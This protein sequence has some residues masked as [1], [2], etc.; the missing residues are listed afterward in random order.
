MFMQ[1]LHVRVGRRLTIGYPLLDSIL[2]TIAVLAASVCV[3]L[4]FC[5]PQSCRRTGVRTTRRDSSQLVRT[6]SRI[7]SPCRP[8][9]PR[10]VRTL[11][12]IPP[13]LPPSSMPRE[14][15]PTYRQTCP[16][17]IPTGVLVDDESADN[18]PAPR[19]N[20]PT[21]PASFPAALASTAV[22]A[23]SVATSIAASA[24]A[25][26]AAAA[27]L[28]ASLATATISTATQPVSLAVVTIS[29]T[30]QPASVATTVPADA[31]SAAGITPIVHTATHVDPPAE[32]SEDGV[33]S[34]T[35]YV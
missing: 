18:A 33:N 30:T 23:A 7:P 8:P 11:A 26:T 25:T 2:I 9:P 12:P 31:I 6:A 35:C 14:L 21:E 4:C 10:L 27:S 5:D 20:A 32:H 13:G 34:N 19:D 24:V 16:S 15:L 1:D 29:T 28:T 17:P 3:L 22:A